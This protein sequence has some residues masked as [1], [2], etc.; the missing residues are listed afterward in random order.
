MVARAT[1][2]CAMAGVLDL[3][4][5]GR[6]AAGRDAVAHG[7]RSDAAERHGAVVPGR[8][9]P[10]GRRATSLHH[11]AGGH[12]CAHRHVGEAAALART[13]R[14]LDLHRRLSYTV[15]GPVLLSTV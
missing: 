9:T 11:A 4:A 1:C 5:A 6:R 8:P 13:A 14:Q 10:A 15:R 2:R 7:D 3:V 12:I